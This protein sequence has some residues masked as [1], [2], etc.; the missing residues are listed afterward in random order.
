M[1]KGAVL[2]IL[3]LWLVVGCLANA[4]A[5]TI[6]QTLLEHSSTTKKKA[7][8][9]NQPKKKWTKNPRLRSASVFVADQK[10]GKVLYKKN[11]DAV[12]PIASITKLM[13]AMVVLDA[14]QKMSQKLTVTEADKDRLKKTGSRLKVGTNLSRKDM[15]CLTLMASENRAASALSRYYP[16][17]R[18]AFVAAMNKKAKEL[19]LK[20]TA[21]K[22]PTG[23]NWKNVSSANDLAKLVEAAH[24]YKQ[25]RK[26]TTRAKHSVTI[27]GKKETFRNTNKLV[28]KSNW[29][30]GLS[31]TGYIKEAGRCL[32]MQAKV[33]NRPTIIVLL[34]SQGRL[35][36]IGDANRIKF[37]IEKAPKGPL[38]RAG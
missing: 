3:A 4:V 9:K 12:V 26:Y 19:N 35:T 6:D 17:G 36:R 28:R 31:K 13:T 2:S 11:A 10:S 1:K 37:W 23:L 8:K 18:K 30:I 24:K 25:I 29:H 33:A 20:E 34:D 32:V 22:E 21:F 5:L 27:Q 7:V 14:K 16:G 15:L 38:N